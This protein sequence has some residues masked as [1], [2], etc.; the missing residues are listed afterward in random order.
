MLLV[1]GCVAQ[2]ELTAD[3]RVLICHRCHADVLMVFHY[4]S[5]WLLRLRREDYVMSHCRYA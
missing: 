3:R 5:R 2:R 1:G 4:F